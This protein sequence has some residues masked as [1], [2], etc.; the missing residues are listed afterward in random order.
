MV[1]I[2]AANKYIPYK[3]G[4][5]QILYIGTTKK[6]AGRPAA[7][8]V[9]KASEV[10]YKLHG[11]KTIDVHIATCAKRNKVQTWKEL[12]SALLDAFRKRYFE[13]PHYNK[14]RPKAKDGLFPAN[15]LV[16][17]INQ[18]DRARH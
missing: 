10:F 5:S 13:L 8:A 3:N 14:V 15:A 17:L 1:Y 6:G 12:E 9:G 11:V 16:K 2:L 18:F 4:R 7:S